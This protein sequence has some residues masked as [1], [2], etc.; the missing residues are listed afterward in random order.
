[1]QDRCYEFQTFTYITRIKTVI[2][3]IYNNPDADVYIM[4]RSIWTDRYI[5]MA[6]L[7]ELAGPL[8]MTMYNEWCDLWA[9]ILPMRV[10]KWVFLD[11]SLEESLRRIRI[12]NRDAESGVNE[13]YQRKLY[14]KHVEFYYKLSNDGFPVVRIDNEL[15]KINAIIIIT[16]PIEP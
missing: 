5:F 14:G 2:N 1:M 8:R 6:L 12:R 16:V 15:M 7:E 10:D 4:E 3:E 11:T 13:D 9:L